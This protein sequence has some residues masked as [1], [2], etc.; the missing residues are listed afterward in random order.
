[1]KWS[2]RPSKPPNNTKRPPM[3]PPR[4]PTTI[5]TIAHT[6]SKTRLARIIATIPR[7]KGR[8]AK[9]NVIPG[10]GTLKGSEMA[11]PISARR[12]RT[13][14]IMPPMRTR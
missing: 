1:M 9:P 10:S 13:I 4:K 8:K 7:I 12:L 3:P 5:R 14:S 11:C 6:S 2:I